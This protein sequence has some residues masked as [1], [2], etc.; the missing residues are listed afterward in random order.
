MAADR[1]KA[2]ALDV[3]EIVRS[4][5]G[6]PRNKFLGGYASLKRLLNLLLAS[7]ANASSL[8]I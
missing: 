5:F 4:A 8:V 3:G 6:Y 2:D 7:F 1:L